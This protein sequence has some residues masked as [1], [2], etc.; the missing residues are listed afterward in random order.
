MMKA[1][2]KVLCLLVIGMV[3]GSGCA[4]IQFTDQLPINSPKGYVEFYIGHRALNP[5]NI[6]IY[7]IQGSNECYIGDMQT[8]KT[9]SGYIRQRVACTPGTNTFNILLVTCN[10]QRVDVAVKEGMVTPVRM[11]VNGGVET[12]GI[13]TY[14]SISLRVT[15]EDPQA[16]IQYDAR[17]GQ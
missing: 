17:T 10:T 7:H 6:S 2:I 1:T 3:F 8:L 9:F 15:A 11:T 14:T 12:R 4:T 13:Y 5:P 16:L